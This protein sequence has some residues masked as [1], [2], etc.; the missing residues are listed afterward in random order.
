MPTVMRS[1]HP[2]FRVHDRHPALH[3][4]AWLVLCLVVVVAFLASVMPGALGP[5]P[6][7]DGAERSAPPR[8]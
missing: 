1:P 8:A 3:G 4:L 6:S 7:P 2:S 5:A